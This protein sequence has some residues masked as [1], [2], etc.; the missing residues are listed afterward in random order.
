MASKAL[1]RRLR[2]EAVSGWELVDTHPSKHSARE[3]V[4][5]LRK[6]ASPWQARALGLPDDRSERGG[7]AG[8]R[9]P[10]GRARRRGP[11]RIETAALQ[12]A[13]GLSERARIA[14][15][16]RRLQLAYGGPGLAQALRIGSIVLAWAVLKGIDGQ[17][18]EAPVA[19]RWL[20]FASG[21]GMIVALRRAFAR[22]FGGPDAAELSNRWGLAPKPGTTLRLKT[23]AE[24][25]EAL[26]LLAVCAFVV[27]RI[28][29]PNFG[30]DL[31]FGIT[32]A[33]VMGSV[34]VGGLWL[35]RMAGDPG[36]D[37]RGAEPPTD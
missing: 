23:D 18:P 3:V 4:V 12:W 31:R 30:P 33:G 6:P 37:T 26:I 21:I 14:A 32:V 36:S 2:A 7:W 9:W 8:L 20:V 34:L 22:G 28:I 25:T 24:R 13:G 29:L 19:F 17:T 27:L 35:E 11:G 10:I 16:P 5:I 1:E 15:E